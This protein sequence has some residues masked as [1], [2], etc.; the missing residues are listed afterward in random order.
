MRLRIAAMMALAAVS[1]AFADTTAVLAF[2]NNSKDQ[3]NLDW[4]GVSIAETI[5][6]SLGSR[7]LL[8]LDRDETE[9]AV[10]RLGLRSR[11]PLSEASVMKIGDVTDAEQVIFGTF[12]F[13]PEDNARAAGLSGSLKISARVLDRRKMHLSPEFTE[14]GALEDLATLQAH[15]AWR[16][17]AMLAP[18][19]APPESEFRSV[20]AP[21][22]LDAEENYVRGLL[23]R[24]PAQKERFFLQAARLDPR[25]SHPCYQLGQIHYRR[26]EYKEAAD[27]LQKIP[28]EDP[29]YR[30]GQFLL[31]LALYQSGDFSGAQKEFQMIAAV[32]PIGEIW[33]NLAAAESRRNLP[34]AVDD[35]RK[36][37]EGDPADPLYQFNLGYALWK[38][39]DFAA[40]AENFRRVLNHDPE[41]TMAT[42]L[43]G[44]CLKQ[45]GY[46]APADER[47]S[48]LERL[49]TV[50]EER[51]YWQLKSV[52]GKSQ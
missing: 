29:H 48:A 13:A 38:K 51:A 21:I 52:L 46:H 8:V 33:N 25:F 32:V 6:E 19:L 44:R 35:F 37:A 5:R 12:E 15:L 16:A 17:L 23:A 41:D 49:K 7:G 24:D 22:R 42:L 43:L 47:L 40:A 11:T 18:R 26:K 39:G 34:Q 10:H 4:I 14:S 45:Q 28:P 50:Y 30:E 31:G 9:D 36:A 3:P 2:W 20:R 1:P 27:W